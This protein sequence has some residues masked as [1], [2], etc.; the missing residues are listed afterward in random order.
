MSGST[1][2]AFG[3][4]KKNSYSLPDINVPDKE[5][6]ENWHKQFVQSIVNRSMPAF[7]TS[8]AFMNEAYNFYLG[9]QTDKSFAFMRVAEDGDV[10]PAQ[11]INFNKIKVK[12]DLMLGELAKKGYEVDVR[13]CN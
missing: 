2:T 3:T 12:I 6:D 4:G 9:A 5:K 10:L 7:D 1:L 13:A 11:W 8:L